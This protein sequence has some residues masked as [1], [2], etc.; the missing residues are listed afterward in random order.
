MNKKITLVSFV[1]LFAMFVLK[2]DFAFGAIVRD[3]TIKVDGKEV[4]VVNACNSLKDKGDDIPAGSNKKPGD[5]KYGNSGE[6]YGYS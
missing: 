3:I 5:F 4:T 6:R 2:S 1:I